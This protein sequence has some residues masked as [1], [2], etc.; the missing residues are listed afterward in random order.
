MEKAETFTISYA[1]TDAG[2]WKPHDGLVARPRKSMAL[3]PGPQ[4]S[5]RPHLQ[6]VQPRVLL[7]LSRSPH[8]RDHRRGVCSEGTSSNIAWHYIRGKPRNE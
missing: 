6:Y 4:S 2:S 1:H 7:Q 5:I 3:V 8:V